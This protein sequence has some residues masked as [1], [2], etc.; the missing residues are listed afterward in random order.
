MGK[1]PLSIVVLF[2]LAGCFAGCGVK[3]PP[4]PPIE[5]LPNA[6][7][8]LKETVAQQVVTLTW[9]A[10]D[11]KE[12][13][14]VERFS[15][16]RSKSDL[17]EDCP[18]CPRLYKRAADIHPGSDLWEGKAGETISYSEELETGFRYSYKV[19]GYT[20]DNIASPDSNPVD[21]DF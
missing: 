5:E 15:V 11:E 16:F 18:E 2:L 8:D 3:N 12:H 13:A 4:L 9:T 7:T 19:V 17:D 20:W 10:P 6:V 14:V 1:K 21:F